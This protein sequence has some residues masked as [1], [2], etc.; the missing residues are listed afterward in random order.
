M[1]GRNRTQHHIRTAN[2]IHVIVQA[3]GDPANAC[4]L[5][6]SDFPQSCFQFVVLVLF[7]LK[8]F[9]DNLFFHDA[10]VFAERAYDREVETWRAQETQYDIKTAYWSV[11]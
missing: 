5:L 8:M 9:P 3:F 7:V 6:S 1:R 4:L 2:H 10:M 11:S